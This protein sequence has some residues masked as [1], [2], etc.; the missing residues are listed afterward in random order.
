MVVRKAS[1]GPSLAYVRRLSHNP[2]LA[3]LCIGR[4]QVLDQKCLF[5][6]LKVQAVN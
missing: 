6:L 4:C 5:E 1:I 3:L 2:Y